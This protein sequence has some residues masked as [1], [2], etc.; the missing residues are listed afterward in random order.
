[1]EEIKTEQPPAQKPEETVVPV[2]K[3]ELTQE[4]YDDLKHK[5]DVSSQNFERLKKAETALGEAESRLQAIEESDP[6][7]SSAEGV[8]L[9]AQ[10]AGLKTQ[11]SEISGELAKKDIVISHPVLK[12][13]WEEFEIFRTDPENSGMNLKTAA[14]SFLVENGLLDI[15]RKGLEKPT[16]GARIPVSSK[17]SSEEVKTLRETNFKKYTEMLEK[18]MLEV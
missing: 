2:K 4:E 3:V 15:P 1:M 9:K 17:M 11:M 7:N 8:V 5:A 10:I 16:G 13:K 6:N 14:K 18:G 12:D